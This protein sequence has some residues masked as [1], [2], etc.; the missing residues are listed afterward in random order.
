[1]LPRNVRKAFRFARRG[2]GGQAKEIDDEIAFHIEERID[3]LVD[4]GWSVEDARTEATRRFGD[5]TTERPALLAAAQL[6]DRR[7]GLFEWFDSVRTD[8]KVTAR[9]LRHAPTFAFGT[10]A[11]FALGLGAN[12]T[13]FNVIDRLL[14]RT[15]AQVATPEYV[16]TMRVLPR[17]QISFPAFVDLRDHLAGAASVSVQTMGWPLP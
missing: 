4:R 6:R 16:Y 5:L 7:V 11:A 3:A 9:Q 13:M 12:A 10:I 17:E 1:M 8:L 14:L 15:P 2:L